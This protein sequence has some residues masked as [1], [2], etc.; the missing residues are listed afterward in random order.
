MARKVADHL[1]TL[2]AN[3]PDETQQYMF[4]NLAYDLGYS[5]EEVRSAISDGG[6]NGITFHISSDDRRALETHKSST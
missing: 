1:N 2:I 6:Y 3:D 4:A 5:P